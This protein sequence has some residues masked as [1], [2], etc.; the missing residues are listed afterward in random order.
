MAKYECKVCGYIYNE[1]QAG[2]PFEELTEC[3]ICNE[4]KSNFK[5][6]EEEEVFFEWAD[7]D[8]DNI[9]DVEVR[10]IEDDEPVVENAV[11]QEMVADTDAEEMPASIEEAAAVEAPAVNEEP[12]VE[13]TPVVNEEPVVEETPAFKEDAVA[14][15]APAANEEPLVEEAPVVNE[16]PVVE[17]APAF[18]E[19]AVAEEAP[20]AKEEPVVTE[21]PT[22]NVVKEDAE[23]ETI[24]PAAAL[25]KDLETAKDINT[26]YVVERR[27]E[28]WS[29]FGGTKTEKA[30]K[31]EAPVK[32]AWSIENAYASVERVLDLNGNEV[33]PEVKE[34]TEEL[35]D[36]VVKEVNAEGA[37]TE[38]AAETETEAVEVQEEM[39]EDMA[40]DEI[41]ED[42]VAEEITEDMPILTTTEGYLDDDTEEKKEDAA[43]AFKPLWQGGTE[44]LPRVAEPLEAKAENVFKVENPVTEVVAEE[45]PKAEEA[46]ATETV[47]EEAVEEETPVAETVV[48]EVTEEAV[49]EETVEEAAEEEVAEEAVGEATEEEVAEEAV[50]E[51]AE[52]AVAEETNEDVVAEDAVKEAV[53]EETEAEE[54]AEEAVAED[55]VEEA[56]AEE[57]E[58]EE[59]TEET[60]AEED[61]VADVVPVFVAP[62]EAV[63]KLK[64]NE[65]FFEDIVTELPD[66]ELIITPDGTEPLP[67]PEEAPV[68]E[69]IE[70]PVEEVVED[71][72]SF[73]DLDDVEES[74][75][76]EVEEIYI[77]TVEDPDKKW[78]F[79]NSMSNTLKGQESNAKRYEFI[80]KELGENVV[81]EEKAEE[82][83]EEIIEEAPVEETI[84]ETAENIEEAVVEVK[85]AAVVPDTCKAVAEGNGLEDIM[86]LPAQLS[87]MPLDEKA[88]IETATVIGLGAERP[89]VLEQPVIK[90]NVKNVV[91]YAPNNG[92]TSED[93]QAADV[94]EIIVGR[95]EG[96]EKTISSKEDLRQAVAFLRLESDGCPIGIKLAAG[97]IERDLEF[98]VFAK[99]DFVVLNKF[100]V[101]PL[102]YALYRAKKYLNTVQ[103]DLD[104]MIEVKDVADADEAA[105]IIAMGA[106]VIVLKD[107]DKDLDAL[108]EQLKKIARETGNY[109]VSDLNV[110]DL[111][112]TNR[113]IA[114]YTDICHV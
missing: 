28:F 68:E 92:L 71:K 112:T 85:P 10:P 42:T 52:E 4:D 95:G 48:E 17:E 43:P 72:F 19:D 27:Q 12:A 39:K 63:E 55:A 30:D 94:I 58:A 2:R 88:V 11:A 60:P 104:L 46:P 114:Q 57:A 77:E 65:E 5:M 90:S 38:K 86:I 108:N 53:A 49:A 82:V 54:A 103:S 74:N 32:K 37:F 23:T 51:V 9:I 113:D 15:E 36:N 24:N 66:D 106:D 93:F 25:M 97:R 6:L 111:C 18:K 31:E 33:K 107:S 89:L 22:L 100:N 35:A 69:V 7:G 109:E 79:N 29:P 76:N 99:P 44:E 45:A 61:K 101:V 21:T 78:T 75:S 64:L 56:V 1:Q 41:A 8:D 70:E 73:G 96:I 67:I 81:V 59:A 62:P 40:T 20:V 84:E 87:P 26:E 110:Q 13:E 47:V 102:P 83:Q 14:E 80:A 16:E 50:G 98:C 105:K 3:P 34:I 91:E